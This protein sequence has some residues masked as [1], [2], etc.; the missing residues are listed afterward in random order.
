MDNTD[1]LF[2]TDK[3]TVLEDVVE[4]TTQ[5]DSTVRERGAECV[6]T[7][8]RDVAVPHRRRYVDVPRQDVRRRP[9]TSNADTAV[10]REETTAHRLP[11][12]ERERARRGPETNTDGRERARRERAWNRTTAGVDSDVPV[13]NAGRSR[14]AN[15]DKAGGQ[16][17]TTTAAE[18]ASWRMDIGKERRALLEREEDAR[19]HIP[20]TEWRSNVS[21]A[22]EEVRVVAPYLA[23]HA[24]EGKTRA[25]EGHEEV[26]QSRPREGH[27]AA[28]CVVEERVDSSVAVHPPGV[29]ER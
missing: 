17:D 5:A 29:G 4:S 14:C 13:P 1:C 11:Q 12:E 3:S 27:H 19:A 2:A 15:V 8:Q 25:P 7:G 6:N 18:Q 24:A 9:T 23:G 21:N 26:V 20:V 28:A 10:Q 16:A 22:Q